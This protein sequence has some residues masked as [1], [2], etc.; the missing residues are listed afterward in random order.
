MRR[1][2]A[3]WS[4]ARHEDMPCDNQQMW[5]PRVPPKRVWLIGGESIGCSRKMRFSAVA[6]L[7]SG[8]LPAQ[9]LYVHLWSGEAGFCIIVGQSILIER[10]EGVG[11][12]TSNADDLYITI[13]PRRVLIQNHLRKEGRSFPTDAILLANTLVIPLLDPLLMHS[14][15]CFPNPSPTS[16]TTQ[17]TAPLTPLSKTLI[18]HTTA[19]LPASS[20]ET[21]SRI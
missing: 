8:Y 5:T 21:P 1:R 4:S 9:R 19:Q 14:L 3:R 13:P 15:S 17:F 2:Q 18:F 10:R 12:E 6:S 16:A 7:V 20:S 11:V